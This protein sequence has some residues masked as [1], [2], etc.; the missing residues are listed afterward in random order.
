MEVTT[1]HA[2]ALQKH[3]AKARE[4]RDDSDRLR[5]DAAREWRAAAQGLASSGM[6]VRDIGAALDVSF[7]RAQQLVRS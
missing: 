2:T 1:Y 3:V 5:A 7:Q 6:T 4:L